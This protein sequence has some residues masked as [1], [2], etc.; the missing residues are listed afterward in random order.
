MKI[1]KSRLLFTMFLL[2]VMMIL[3]ID[4]VSAGGGGVPGHAHP[5]SPEPEPEPEP[6]APEPEPEPEPADAPADGATGEGTTGGEIADVEIDAQ[7]AAEVEFGDGA[8]AEPPT[9]QSA[10]TDQEGENIW[11]VGSEDEPVYV[12][13][14]GAD[15]PIDLYPPTTPADAPADAPA[16][17]F[18]TYPERPEEPDAP[19]DA[20]PPTVAE[21]QAAVDAAQT[22]YDRAVDDEENPAEAQ[23]ALDKAEQDLEDA[24]A[25]AAAAAVA[26]ATRGSWSYND[27][28]SWIKGYEDYDAL[29]G[30]LLGT[31]DAETQKRQDEL[32]ED[33]CE[34]MGGIG[35]ALVKDC[36]IAQ[37][38]ESE[39]YD[40]EDIEGVVVGLTASGEL[41]SVMHAEGWRTPGGV[42][43]NETTGEVFTDVSRYLYKATW[44]VNMAKLEAPGAGA[45]TELVGVN[46]NGYNVLFKENS[47]IKHRY[48]EDWYM[49]NASES[50]GFTNA[51]PFLTY[52]NNY[53]D[54]LCLVLQTPI[55]VTLGIGLGTKSYSE[56]CND[57]VEHT[58]DPTLLYRIGT[59]PPGTPPPG[60]SGGF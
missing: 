20:A 56:I 17:T 41:I 43:I 51:N 3:L 42:F 30:W 37:M 14:S 6:A 2:I 44:Y 40:F 26:A 46:V 16:D 19:A 5:P 58:G 22:E 29:A 45:I 54:E 15:V 52:S 10:G 59:S 25:A 50:H 31:K 11:N 23:A 21:A 27:P 55:D 36:A 9:G 13:G 18:Y 24:G 35:A 12:Y 48:Y 8:D 4:S 60:T 32:R 1:K 38:C 47:V 7:D 34:G 53:Y 28:S 33:F 39:L 57:L 49:L